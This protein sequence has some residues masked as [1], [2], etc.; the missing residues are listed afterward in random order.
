MVDVTTAQV[1]DAIE[2]QVFAVIGMVNAKGQAR[3]A[4]V[5]I[6]TEKGKVY[7]A[8]SPDEW[9]I[10]HIAGNEHVSVTI[11]IAKRLPF[12]PMV[13]IPAAT[14]TFSG[15]ARLLE[16]DEASASVLKALTGGIDLDAPAAQRMVIAEITPAGDFVTYGVGVRL[17]QMRDTELARGRAPV[18]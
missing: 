18:T 8:S 6:T 12:L 10:R 13:K 9:K 4:G 11:P 14:I 15:T 17:M 1:W 2:Q 7:F 5:V 3:T 16:Q